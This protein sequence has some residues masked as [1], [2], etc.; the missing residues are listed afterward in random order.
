MP[1]EIV[2]TLGAGD[3]LIAAFIAATLRGAD[4]RD[5]LR[6]GAEAAADACGHPG[7]WP[8]RDRQE[9]R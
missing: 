3:A 4:A 5:S 1:A 9:A 7:A 2:D 6:A 8:V